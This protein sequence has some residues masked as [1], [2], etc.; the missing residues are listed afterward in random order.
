[1]NM[2]TLNIF[3]DLSEKIFVSLRSRTLIETSE[4][5]ALLASL[6]T[7]RL[8]YENSTTIPKELAAVLFDLSTA[9]YSA[10]EAY[11]EEQQSSLYGLFDE[12]SDRAR[13][14]LN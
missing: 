2:N 5:N 13:A 10:I 1:M 7:L 4:V 9:I 11:P 8:Q 3:L 12:F 14:L 6:D